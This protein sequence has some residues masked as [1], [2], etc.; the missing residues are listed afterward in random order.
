MY[1]DVGLDVVI[2]TVNWLHYLTYEAIP[3]SSSICH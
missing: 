3:R 2:W 1:I